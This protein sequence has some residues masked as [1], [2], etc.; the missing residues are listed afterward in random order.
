MDT[1]QAQI[2]TTTI[3]DVKKL[4]DQKGSSLK[5]ATR[6]DHRALELAVVDDVVYKQGLPLVISN[7]TLSWRRDR[8]IFSFDWLKKNFGNVSMKPR[9][10]ETYQDLND[11][12]VADY[13]DYISTPKEKRH[14]GRLY[15]KDMPCP[16]Q[17][18]D[19]VGQRLSHFWTKGENDLLASMMIQLQPETL[20]IYVGDDEVCYVTLALLSAFLFSSFFLLFFFAYLLTLM[21]PLFTNLNFFV[22]CL[23]TSTDVHTWP[24][25]HCWVSRS[26]R[27]GVCRRRW[28]RIVGCNCYRGGQR[29]KW[30]L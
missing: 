17:W 21:P 3:D 9:D 5:F 27:D 24:F 23:S 22:S 26:Q 19:F 1:Y 11:W 12:R 18:K 10:V 13:L 14:Q 15:G 29:E 25:G 4:I 7:T 16:S 30:T 28:L 8:E 6:V 2:V 20:L